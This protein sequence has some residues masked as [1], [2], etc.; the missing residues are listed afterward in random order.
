MTPLMV[1]ALVAT[2]IRPMSITALLPEAGGI[3]I[4]GALGRGRPG[5]KQKNPAPQSP[6]ATDSDHSGPASPRPLNI[7]LSGVPL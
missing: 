1:M 5:R 6:H 2:R 7:G 3:V 4:P